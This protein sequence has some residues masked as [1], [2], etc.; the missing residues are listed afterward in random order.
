MP[1]IYISFH[2]PTQPV[3]V[4]INPSA[5]PSAHRSTNALRCVTE[6]DATTMILSKKQQL[7]SCPNGV[8]APLH[9][10]FL[11]LSCEAFTTYPPRPLP[12]ARSICPS[13][14]SSDRTLFC[15]L[16]L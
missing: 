8:P 14:V 16:V 1:S 15:W 9:H 2:S 11:F 6:G 3:A 13:A 5:R 10:F 7:L 4:P 12:S